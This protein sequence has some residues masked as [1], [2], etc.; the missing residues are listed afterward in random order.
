MKRIAWMMG[1]LVSLFSAA[2]MG[3]PPSSAADAPAVVVGR[4]YHIEGDLLRYVPEEND[5]VAVV[6]DAPFGREDTLFS[7]SRGMGELIAPNGTWIRV[8]NST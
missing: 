2:V 1:L 7:G 4:V 5:W 3:V 6:K 8:G